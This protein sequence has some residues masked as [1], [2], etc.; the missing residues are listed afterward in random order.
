MAV[1]FG[2][3]ERPGETVFQRIRHFG[4]DESG[5]VM[6][7]VNHSRTP[8]SILEREIIKSYFY[9]VLAD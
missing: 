8:E 6:V 7:E 9:E 1:V 3:G 4:E 5:G 2:I